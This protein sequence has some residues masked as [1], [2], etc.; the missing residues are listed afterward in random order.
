MSW[1][2]VV[3]SKASNSG[4]D[5]LSQTLAHAVTWRERPSPSLRR[6]PVFKKVISTML[7]YGAMLK[8]SMAS[9]GVASWIA[10][11][12]DTRASHFPAQAVGKGKMTPD[13]SGLIFGESSEKYNPDSASSKTWPTIFG[14]DLNQYGETFAQWATRLRQESIRRRRLARHISGSDFSYMPTPVPTKL[15]ATPTSRDHKDG[16]NPSLKEPTNCLLGRQAPRT[17]MLGQKFY[18][19]KRALNPQFVEWLMGFPIGWTGLQP[20][21]TQSYQQWQQRHGK[22]LEKG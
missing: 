12:V 1:L 20:L 5:S 21:E 18:A 2:Y 19:S 8:P 13:T 7:Q 10:S 17:P 16:F 15:W 3:G 6:S 9:R 11:L 4:C 14:S 22:N